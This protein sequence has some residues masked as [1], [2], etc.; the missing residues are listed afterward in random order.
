MVTI[1]INNDGP[2]NICHIKE[3][4]HVKNLDGKHNVNRP[5]SQPVKTTRSLSRYPRV[6]KFDFP[7]ASIY[8]S[9]HFLDI[10]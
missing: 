1:V 4:T 10:K 5:T 6:Q 9:K 3:I 7:T 8:L 2:A